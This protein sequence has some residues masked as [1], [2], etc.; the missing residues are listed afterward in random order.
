MSI[1]G[2]LPVRWGR[3]SAGRWSFVWRGFGIHVLPAP[4]FRRWGLHEEW[5][6]G[7]LW[8]L[9]V[10]PL[11]LVS[12]QGSALEALNEPTDGKQVKP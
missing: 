10:G 12:W 4:E 9:S 6:D 2:W 8:D 7:P 11:L 5:Y 1:A 3:P